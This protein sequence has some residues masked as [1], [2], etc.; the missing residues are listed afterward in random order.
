MSGGIGR[1]APPVT[2]PK[3]SLLFCWRGRSLCFTTDFVL[4]LTRS[5]E[6]RV[7]HPLPLRAFPHPSSST[8]GKITFKVLTWDGSAVLHLD[9]KQQ[10]N[11]TPEPQEAVVSCWV[12]CVWKRMDSNLSNQNYSHFDCS[13]F[14]FWMGDLLFWT[15]H[16]HLFIFFVVIQNYFSTLL[17]SVL[18][19]LALC[20]FLKGAYCWN[21]TA[22]KVHAILRGPELCFY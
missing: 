13:Q 20:F 7:Y 8:V 18:C 22:N 6:A 17:W 11:P 2:V 1:G 12:Q 14:S 5:S 9:L 16:S 15:I 4:D 19:F 3:I 10:C 21:E